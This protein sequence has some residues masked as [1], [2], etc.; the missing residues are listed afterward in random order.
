MPKLPG[1]RVQALARE[2]DRIRRRVEEVG[3][4]AGD[5]VSRVGETDARV[6]ALR[7]QVEQ[8]AA[9][10][11]RAVEAQGARRPNATPPPT[12]LGADDAAA[13]GDLVRD[14]IP[15]LDAVYLRYPGAALPTCWLWHPWV[16]EELAW[17]AAAHRAAY[18]P[19]HGTVSAAAEWH[20]RWRPGVAKRISDALGNCAV[21]DHAAGGPKAAPAL[22]TPLQHAHDAIAFA[23]TNTRTTPEPTEFD[24]SE[25]MEHDRRQ[26][27]RNH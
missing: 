16:V 2:Q 27:T 9:G 1:D 21:S 11:A 13:A 22:T 25:A 19:D 24:L 3:E 10:V 6:D 12:W 14:L 20:E 4:Q 5:A 26:H 15:W 8:L 23:W 18:D 17:L 7:G